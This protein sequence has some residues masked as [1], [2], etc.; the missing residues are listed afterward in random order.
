M[1][2]FVSF[3]GIDNGNAKEDEVGFVETHPGFVEG[4]GLIFL[5]IQRKKINKPKIS[6]SEK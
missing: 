3:S 4:Q 1:G 6:E 2:S 5:Q